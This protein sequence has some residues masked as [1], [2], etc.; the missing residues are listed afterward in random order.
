VASGAKAFIRSDATDFA[1]VGVDW[2]GLVVEVGAYT[3]SYNTNGGSTIAAQAYA[4]SIAEPTAPTRAGYTFAGWTE[5]DGGS[6]TITFPYAPSA[7]SNITLYA[8]WNRIYTV[9]YTYNSAT[10]GNTVASN[11][12]VTG[13]TAITLPTPTRTGYTFAGWHSD[14][15]LTSKIA[16]AGSSYSPTGETSAITVYA[17]WTRNPVKAVVS[18]KP[19]ITGKATATIKGTNKLTAKK[20]TWTGYPTP[21]ISYQWYSCTAQVKSATATI[22]KSCKKISKATKSTLAVTNTF[23]GKFIAVAVTG[24]G[25]GTTATTWLSKS[26]AKVK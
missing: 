16:D 10:G 23:K 7:T 11:T 20:G 26:T 2:N 9:T 8:K 6:T 3:V 24:K 14:A 19:T 15:G 4:R 22:P 21:V 12:F 18:T 13:D 1:N 5:T 25:T 17:K